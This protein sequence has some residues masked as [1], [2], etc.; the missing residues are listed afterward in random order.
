MLYFS[1]NRKVVGTKIVLRNA[2]SFKALSVL[3]RRRSV[4]LTSLSFPYQPRYRDQSKEPLF[5]FLPPFFLFH[6]IFERRRRIG[7]EDRSPNHRNLSSTSRGV[8]RFPV[9]MHPN[10]FLLVECVKGPRWRQFPCL[11]C[12][13]GRGDEMPLGNGEE[14]QSLPD[15]HARL[16]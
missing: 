12:Q 7:F 16:V 5:F 6:S 4:D 3:K 2:C 8:V 9:G 11:P 10:S 14:S 15:T 13:G 1:V